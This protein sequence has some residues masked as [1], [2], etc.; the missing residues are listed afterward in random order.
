M[1]GDEF[2]VGVEGVEV[3][4]MV[5]AREELAALVELAGAYAHIAVLYCHSHLYH[6]Q[7][8][9]PDAVHTAEG[10]EVDERHGCR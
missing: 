3:E 9:E 1:G 8:G 4:Q 5:L 6:L 10:A 2:I 7:V